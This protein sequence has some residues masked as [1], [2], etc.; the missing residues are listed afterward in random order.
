MKKFIKPFD[1]EEE[2]GIQSSFFDEDKS[3]EDLSSL[4]VGPLIHHR[5]KGDMLYKTR[6]S[7]CPTF[8]NMSIAERGATLEHCK[9]C[10]LCLDW[11]GEHDRTNFT[12]Q[13]KGKPISNCNVRV[14]SSEYEKIHNILL[15]GSKVCDVVRNLSMPLARVPSYAV[16]TPEKLNSAELSQNSLLPFQEINVMGLGRKQKNC[17]ASFDTGSDIKL[18]RRIFADWN[19]WYRSHSTPPGY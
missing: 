19:V 15:H 11:T 10:A 13:V 5:Q 3:G 4:F 1:P 2:R 14:G 12:S 18:I 16:P 8:K 6:L 7:L 9:G 17:V